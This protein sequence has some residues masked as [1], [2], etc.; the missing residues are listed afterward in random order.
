MHSRDIP[1]HMSQPLI[2]KH[3]VEALQA[4]LM[5]QATQATGRID[6]AIID[7]ARMICAFE[8]MARTG[9]LTIAQGGS[10]MRSVG[11]S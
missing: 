9:I 1:L 7:E 3:E 5:R 10:L 11:R 8:I 6:A 2:T 4:T